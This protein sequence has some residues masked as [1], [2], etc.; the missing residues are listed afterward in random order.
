TMKQLYL[1]LSIFCFQLSIAQSV[2]I[3][4]SET[5][6]AI[7][8]ANIRINS[9]TFVSNAEGYFSIP[10]SA[11]ADSNVEISYIGYRNLQVPIHVLQKQD[12]IVKMAPATYSLDTVIVPNK[13]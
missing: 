10:F 4:D 1:I 9:E 7:P 13:R 3:I 12:Y 8:F 6:E 11:D 2:K 5:N